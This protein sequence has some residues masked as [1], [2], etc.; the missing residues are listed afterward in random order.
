MGHARSEASDALAAETG[1]PARLRPL[2]RRACFR[3][4]A[5]GSA[6]QRPRG[7]LRSDANEADPSTPSHDFEGPLRAGGK[8]A[9]ARS[10]RGGNERSCPQARAVRRLDGIRGHVL[11]PAGCEPTGDRTAAAGKRSGAR[12]ARRAAATA[13]RPARPCQRQRRPGE[14]AGRRS[15]RS[16]RAPTP[17]PRLNRLIRRRPFDGLRAD[18]P[19]GAER[20]LSDAGQE[21]LVL[22]M[23]GTFRTRCAQISSQPSQS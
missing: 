18:H 1:Y 3:S 7:G 6:E 23:R 20:H 10:R 2:A 11:R 22:K 21:D 14:A 13:A 17:R 8:P 9:L 4:R 16:G 12:G 5:V 19:S 15:C